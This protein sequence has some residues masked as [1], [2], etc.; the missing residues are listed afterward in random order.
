MNADQY[1]EEKARYGLYEK[2]QDMSKKL[3]VI[4]WVYVVSNV[5]GLVNLS[6]YLVGLVFSNSDLASN[7]QLFSQLLSCI[8]AIV[9]G[10][11]ILTMREYDSQLGIAG[12]A[13]IVGNVLNILESLFPN[14]CF[15]TI[16]SMIS[17]VALVI[18]FVL[19][20]SSFSAD[21]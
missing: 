1:Y 4:F 2:Y 10:I 8:A 21:I 12:L 13:Y 6:I 18:Y 17:S 20:K 19:Y 5:L 3:G 16:M 9:T 7:I 11:M 15:G 14:S